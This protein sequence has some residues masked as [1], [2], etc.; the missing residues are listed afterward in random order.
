MN[1]YVEW[2][3]VPDVMSKETFYK[4]CHIS[5]ATALE[6]LQTKKVPCRYIKKIHTYR[7]KKADVMKY[8]EERTVFSGEYV[9]RKKTCNKINLSYPNVI[10]DEIIKKLHDYYSNMFA[11]VPE[12]LKVLDVVNL[13]GYRRATILNW[14]SKKYFEH[15][16]LYRSTNYFIPKIDIIDFLCS[17]RAQRIVSKS[18]WHIE[19]IYDFE[20]MINSKRA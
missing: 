17:R 8:M 13:I 7:I 14:C 4:V 15:V 16:R 18:K 1:N 19:A 20:D 11:D 5:K 2:D 9:Q 10:P 6:L 12:K 3:K